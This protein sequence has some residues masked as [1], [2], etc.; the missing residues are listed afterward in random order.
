MIGILTLGTMT[1]VILLGA[2]LASMRKPK[3]VTLEERIFRRKTAADLDKMDAEDELKWLD[4]LQI[5][6]AQSGVGISVPV[7]LM[8]GLVSG[9]CVYFV[10]V[11]LVGTII[12]ALLGAGIVGVVL[13]RQILIFLIDRKKSEFDLAFSK[14]LK[15]M[16]A[17]MKTGGTLLQAVQGVAEAGAM[18][19]SIREEMALV[20]MDYDY[21]DSLEVAF[22]H[23]YDRTG[24]TDV[25]NMAIAIEIGLRQGSKLYEVFDNYVNTIMGRKE[26]EADGRATLSD[27]KTSTNVLVVVPF[28]FAAV[29]KFLQPT[30]FDGAFA[31][32]G[33]LGKYLFFILYSF[34]IFGFIYL[35]KKCN[36]RI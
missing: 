36:I 18:P 20:L 21:G 9:M 6:L 31:Y 27:I 14:A 23:M 4:K 2:F 5:E 17:T 22:Y 34:V 16:S 28:G 12:A 25:K 30:Y 24:L 10:I 35:R 33:G 13:P 29:L 32:A 8:I 15:R 26:I 3:K 7:Y 19:K 11:Y 1:V